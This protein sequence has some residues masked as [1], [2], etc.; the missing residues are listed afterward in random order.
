MP[1]VPGISTASPIRGQIQNIENKFTGGFI[2][3]ASGLNFPENACT[4]V[5]NV[6]FD[7]L[8]TVQRR[9]GINFESGYQLN[10]I[11][12]P[13]NQGSSS[14]Y[15]Q[16]AAGNGTINIMVFQ[17]GDVLYFYQSVSGQAL[18]ANYLGAVSVATYQIS[19][20]PDPGLS[21]CQYASGYGNLY[22]VNPSCDPMVIT[23]NPGVG[24]I[25]A[26]VQIQIR[27]FTGFLESGNPAVTFRPQTLTAEHNYNLQNQG[28]TGAPAWTATA[29]NN[30][31]SEGGCPLGNQTFTV[32]SGISGISNG[33]YVTL[34][35]SNN[36]EYYNS[37]AQQYGDTVAYGTATGTVVSYSGTS[38]V[39]DVGTTTNIGSSYQAEYVASVSSAFTITPG[40]TANTIN[41][42]Y[43]D[44]ANYPSNSDIWFQYKDDGTLSG[45]NGVPTFNPTNTAGQVLQPTTQAPQGHFI[46]PAF[47][48]NRTAASSIASLTTVTTTARPTTV[49]WFQGRVFFSGV[50]GSQQAS[51]DAQYYSWNQNIYFSQILEDDTGTTVGFCYQEQDPTDEYLFDLLSSDGGVIRIPDA[52]Q[53]VKLYPIQGALIVFA[54]NGIWTITGNTGLGFTA[55]DYSVNKL[56]SIKCISGTSFV[57]VLGFPVWWTQ[58]GI[59]TIRVDV[60]AGGLRVDSLTDTTIKTFYQALPL[61]SKINTVGTYNPLDF[62]VTFIYYNPAPSGNED[63]EFN[64]A[65]TFNTITGAWSNWT[66]SNNVEIIGLMNNPIGQRSDAS[67]SPEGYTNMYFCTYASGGNSNLTFAQVIDNQTWLDW[68]S[69]DGIGQNY[70]S[71]FECG[72]RVHG[73]GARRFQTNYVFVYS[74]NSVATQY[75][76]QGYWNYARQVTQYTSDYLGPV[77]AVND[78]LLL[79]TGSDILLET[80]GNLFLE[81]SYETVAPVTSVQTMIHDGQSSDYA[82]RRVKLRGNGMSAQLLISSVKG[83]PFH[84]I[85]WAIYESVNQGV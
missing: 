22:V 24:F 13:T 54:S 73:Q 52:G 58:E 63:F 10:T 7:L 38:L 75:T 25:V 27:D 49:A 59:Y 43:T 61:Q 42:W 69:Y 37:V 1:R 44:L 8:G 32:A 17:F 56:S 85:G 2:T 46:L 14:F 28:W 4:A 20:S 65:L 3:E 70:T 62:T 35:W 50:N 36:Y 53:I 45:D 82:Y 55:D 71:Y 72:Y 9:E 19:G 18:S 64:S 84:I 47:N 77:G 40:Q 34:T 30:I 60:T 67:G 81:S 29:T 16:A 6:V 15:W 68:H 39:I 11:T 57:D 78:D 41:T 33:Q 5:S 79:E 76:I 51:G 26:S 12:T 74:N 23:Y 83:Q 48:M 66:F 31:L 80:S 21:S